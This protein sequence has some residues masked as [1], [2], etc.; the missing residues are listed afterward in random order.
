MNPLI[1][2]AAGAPRSPFYPRSIPYA[3]V[4]NDDDVDGM[5]RTLSS[6]GDQKTFTVSFW[7]KRANLTNGRV[8]GMAVDGANYSWLGFQ[9]NALRF[10]NSTAGV[11]VDM[12][13]TALYRDPTNYMHVCMGIDTTQAV[14]ADRF[15]FEV[16][17]TEVTAFATSDYPALNE[18]LKWNING[19]VA[20]ITAGDA[21]NVIDAYLAE[22]IHIDGTLYS[23]SDFG[24]SKNGAWV[25]KASLSLTYG[26]NGFKLDFSNSGDLGEDSANSNDFTVNGSP[27]QVTDTPTNNFAVMNNL[28]RN[29]AGHVYSEGNRKIVTDGGAGVHRGDMIFDIAN[30]DVYWEIDMN[31]TGDANSGCGIMGVNINTTNGEN[32][33]DHADE[34]SYK[35]DGNKRNNSANAAYGASYTTELIRVACTGGAIY[36]AKGSGDTWCDG[37]GNMDQPWST[38]V[39]A[40]SGLTGFFTPA[41]TPGGAAAEWMKVNFGNPSFTITS[42]NTDDNGYGDFEDAPPS[43]LLALCSA[44]I[45]K[46]LDILNSID[47]PS[48]AIYSKTRAGT[49]AEATTSDVDFDVSAGALIVIKNRDQADEW[50][51]VDT[52]RGAT[53]HLSWDSVNVEATEAQGVK[54][55][56]STGYVLGTGA[57]G[58]NDNGENFLDWVLRVGATY[59][60]DI[61]EDAGTGVAHAIN[62]SLGVAPSLI[63]RKQ[64]DGGDSWAVYH[65]LA[66]SDSET[67]YAQVDTTNAFSDVATIWDDTA[68]TSTQFTVGTN[69]TTNFNGRNFVTYLFA[70]IP[71][72][73]KAF[74]YTGN[75]NADGPYIPLGMKTG[76][77]LIKNVAAVTSWNLFDTKRDLYN[78]MDIDF[79]MESPNAEVTNA[80]YNK[81]VLSQGIKIR[82][83]D[84]QYNS[85]A[86]LYVGFAWADQFGCYSNAR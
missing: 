55:F 58:Y 39:A 3:G 78:V 48:E 29:S 59:G 71:G 42:G 17:G 16:D 66:A 45:A 37:S 31:V 44:N 53:E 46:S 52:E 19:E 21:A 57:N 47:Q 7:I 68:P 63:I 26:T 67:D 60:L 80:L 8:L 61:V 13:T 64:K 35:A 34:Y 85:N 33:G 30:D 70:D 86:V 83:A 14:E 9:E 50:K 1:A 12:K 32:L 74:A 79:R 49:G 11:T 84:S 82:T 25:P 40:Y 20:F 43:G 54:S 22:F 65:S 6:A 36:F 27:A 41:V 23:A 75:G 72:L 2:A 24:Q 73:C 51:V 56:S 5:Q 62:H 69:N 18:D 10:Y 28:D 38:A 4:F 76:I 81:D 77:G 15:T